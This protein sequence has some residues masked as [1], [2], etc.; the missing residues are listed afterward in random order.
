MADGCLQF[1]QMLQSI[2]A[3]VGDATLQRAVLWVNHL[4][5]A[6]PAARERLR[7]HAGKHLRLELIDWPAVMPAP[8]PARLTVTPAGLF[9]AA[10]ADAEPVPGSAGGTPPPADLVLR[11]A[12]SDPAGWLVALTRGERPA[13][14]VQGDAQLAGE[15]QWLAA[16]LRWDA[17]GDLARFTGGPVAHQLASLGRTLR[18]G[19]RRW[20][21][22]APDAPRRP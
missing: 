12:A 19:L 9:E 15:L 16:N 18:D 2:L 8:P 22:P 5:T 11:I 14:D 10:D 3:S 20:I 13:V 1:V 4:L 17:E 21:P 7:A 6:E